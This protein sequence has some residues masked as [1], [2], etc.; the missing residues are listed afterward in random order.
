MA[1]ILPANFK[2]DIVGNDTNLIPVLSIGTHFGTMSWADTDTW[3]KNA[4]HLS[5]N[6]MTI[7]SGHLGWQ[8]RVSV[9]TKPI[10]LNIPSLKESIDI[11]KRNYKISSINIDISNYEYEGKRFSEL[12]SHTSLINSEVRI[13]W[14]SQSGRWIF[15][16]ERDPCYAAATGDHVAG[17]GLQIYFGTIRRYTHD[18]EKV[19]LA[20]E[21]RSQV[22]LHRDLPSTYLGDSNKPVPMVYGY[23]D[24]SPC[25]TVNGHRSFVAD[26]HGVTFRSELNEF[27][28][29][30]SPLYFN[31][32]SGYINVVSN[33]IDENDNQLY[34]IGPP[35]ADDVS[36]EG[37]F[38]LLCRNGN[39]GFQI[40]L[41]NSIHNADK[42]SSDFI[43]EEQLSGIY[44]GGN[45]PVVITNQIESDL[46]ATAGNELLMLKM[47]G[48]DRF[49]KYQN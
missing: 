17:M 48:L 46:T 25:F 29:Y 27:G 49:L 9:V 42:I 1:L 7:E 37:D 13:Y 24:R 32:P 26:E 39:S 45:N 3:F 34:L 47:N 43:P 36:E 14:M 21:D 19:R 15:P 41:S 11:E 20:V 6:L 31:D 44:S 2:N 35:T 23:V 40:T 8:D 16:N 12:V 18:D 4:I 10:L 38:R 5:T 28:T 30:D 22:T 33:Q